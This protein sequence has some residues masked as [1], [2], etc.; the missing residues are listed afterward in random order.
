M[1]LVI[2]VPHGSGIRGIE[3][4][5]GTDRGYPPIAKELIVVLPVPGWV[6]RH[7]SPVYKRDAALHEIH[8]AARSTNAFIPPSGFTNRKH[9]ARH[10]DVALGSGTG[11]APLEY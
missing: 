10:S 8:A 9:L 2:I 5:P 1:W 6:E 3:Q 4:N 7:C 11:R